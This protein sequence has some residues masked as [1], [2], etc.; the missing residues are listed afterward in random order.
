MPGHVIDGR[1][2]RRLNPKKIWRPNYRTTPQPVTAGHLAYLE[3]RERAPD[4]VL[5]YGITR[6]G[7]WARV[8]DSRSR[9]STPEAAI[10]AALALHLQ[11]KTP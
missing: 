3:A 2:P 9:S 6:S 8:G 10:A 1:A 7:P 5:G 4:A 11:E